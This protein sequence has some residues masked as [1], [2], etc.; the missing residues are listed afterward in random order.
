LVKSHKIAAAKMMNF[1]PVIVTDM[2]MNKL[3]FIIICPLFLKANGEQTVI[4]LNGERDFDP[5]H[6]D[7]MTLHRGK[8][9]PYHAE[10][11]PHWG[12][13]TPHRGKTALLRGEIIQRRG[14][15][16]LH[17]G[18]IIQ[19]YV[20]TVPYRGET[21]PRHEYFEMYHNPVRNKKK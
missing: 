11:T 5:P 9:I 17:C 13:M 1:M 18:K 20:E 2:Y 12:K 3:F 21:V 14:K 16:T 15:M 19:R 4:F 10:T 6:C 7:K 8:I